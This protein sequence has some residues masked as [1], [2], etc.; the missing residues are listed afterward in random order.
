M[1]GQPKCKWL[2]ERRKHNTQKKNTSAASEIILQLLAKQWNADHRDSPVASHQTTRQT[3][4]WE[5]KKNKQTNRHTKQ[6][7]TANLSECEGKTCTLMRGKT[8]IIWRENRQRGEIGFLGSDLILPDPT[9]I[10]A[11]GI[12]LNEETQARTEYGR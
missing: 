8:C 12:C 6:W 4:N 11:S 9:P 7:G 5:A 10:K 3:A 2:C 1:I